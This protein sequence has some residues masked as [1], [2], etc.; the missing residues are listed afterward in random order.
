MACGRNIAGAY[1][2]ALNMEYVAELQYRALCV[3]TPN[4]LGKEAMADVME[5]FK[6]Y[7]QPDKQKPGY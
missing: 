7:G 6:S 5:R 4:V 1:G 2:L 3:G